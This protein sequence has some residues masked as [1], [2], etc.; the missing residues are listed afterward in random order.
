MRRGW[1]NV[2]EYEE[3]RWSNVEEYEEGWRGV[4]EYG[5]EVEWCKRV[6]G[7]GGIM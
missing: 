2:E 4:E 3:V 1:S 5:E 6:H 7:E